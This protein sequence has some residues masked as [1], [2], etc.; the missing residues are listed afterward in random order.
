MP[1][2]ATIC[3][4]AAQVANETAPGQPGSE[5]C[6]VTLPKCCY[7]VLFLHMPWVIT[8]VLHALG[9]HSS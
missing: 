8:L 7:G 2:L 6:C 1:D 4:L 3:G 9:I 5:Q